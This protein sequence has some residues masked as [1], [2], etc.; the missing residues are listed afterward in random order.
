MS[1]HDTELHAIDRLEL[2]HKGTARLEAPVTE[3]VLV[4][5]N[6]LEVRKDRVAVGTVFTC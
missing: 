3:I 5:G 4:I 6:E 2:G 1:I